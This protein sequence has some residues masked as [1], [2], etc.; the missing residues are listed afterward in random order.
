MTFWNF[1]RGTGPGAVS[2]SAAL[3]TSPE[4]APIELHTADTRMVGWIA[5]D[6]H[7]VTDLLRDRDTV[8]LWQPRPDSAEPGP[9]PTGDNGGEWRSIETARVVVVMPPEWRPT[10]Q[11]R[12]HRRLQRVAVEAGP[13]SITGNLHLPTDADPSPLASLPNWIPLTDVHLLFHGDPPFEHVV[14]VAIVNAAHVSRLAPLITL[15]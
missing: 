3:S 7:R 14:S 12:L 8:R 2:G 9:R 4:L 1:R 10:R 13:F 6:G 11:L 15:A 5:A